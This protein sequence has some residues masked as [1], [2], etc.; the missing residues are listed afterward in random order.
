[1]QERRKAQRLLTPYTALYCAYNGVRA[2]KIKD[3]SCSGAAI[4]FKEPI[5]AVKGAKIILH[6]YSRDLHKLIAK[7]KCQVIREFRDND[8]FA[9][10]INFLDEEKGI[11]EIMSFLESKNQPV[12]AAL[13]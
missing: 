3:L 13:Q 8:H 5:A 1:M 2:V 12:S 7:L 10:G 11:A 6:F 4:I 9:I